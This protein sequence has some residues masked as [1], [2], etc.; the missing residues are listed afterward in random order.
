MIRRLLAL[1]SVLALACAAYAAEL[2]YTKVSA[3]SVA[4]TA[5]VSGS[6]LLIVNDGS[7][8]VFVRVFD[9]GETVTAATSANSEIKSG[10]SMEF[11]RP[12]GIASVSLICSAGESATVRL[13]YW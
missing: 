11:D 12:G 6:S 7:N 3:S 10:E 2:G 9:V 5:N 4:Q 13:F 8:E 1:V